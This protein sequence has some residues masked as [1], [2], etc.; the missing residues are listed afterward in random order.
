[1]KHSRQAHTP[2]VATGARSGRSS[3][4]EPLAFVLVR[5]PLL[6]VETYRALSA[7]ARNGRAWAAASGSVA[8]VP[9]SLVP[10]DPR[11][12]RALA[13]GSS[14]LLR[15]L[16]RSAPT[17]KEA[18]YT[19]GKLLR[20]LIRM[21]TRPTPY[22]L[23]AGVALGQWGSHTD[24]VL[25]DAPPRTRTRPDMAWLLSFVLAQEARPEVRAQLCFMANP[26]AYIHGDRV[27]L[28][29]RAP[30]EDGGA[31]PTVSLR[32]TGVVRRALA[33]VRTPI[34][35]H[36]LV[37]RLLTSTPGAT[38][39]QVERLIS[40]LWQHTLLLT[41]VRPPL[42]TDNPAR[43]VAQRLAA[44]PA[45]SEAAT[46]LKAILEA[47]AVW[48]T[49]PPEEGTHAYRQLVG[50]AG[51]ITGTISEPFQVDMALMLKGRQIAAT[52]GAEV[53]RAAELLLRQTPLPHGLP[54]MTAYRRAFEARYGPEREVPL[55]ELLDPDHG[56]GPPAGYGNAGVDGGSDAARSTLRQQTLRNLA[57]TAL[58]DRRL[59]VELD[60]DTLARLETWAPT[61]TT[62]PP[63][64]DLN[65][66]IA[67]PSAAA[68]DAGQF[69]IIIGPNLGAQ[70]A[71]RNLGRFADLLAPEAYFAL[72]E[73]ARAEAAR[74]PAQLR[75]ELVYLPRWF[76]SANV[77]IRPATRSHEIALA[78]SGGVDHS[79]LIPLDELLVGVRNGRF[80]IRW[81]AGN[82][83]VVVCAGH[84]LN[85]MQAPVVCQFLSDVSH[86]GQAHLS[87]FDWGM[88]AG[89][90]FLPRVQMGRS[91]LHPAQWRIDELARATELPVDPPAAFQQALRHWR[92]HWQVPQHVYL[93][94]GDNRLLLDLEDA[95]QTEELCAERR[96][97]HAG[98]H[99]VLQEALPA[100]DQI[101]LAG[102]GGHYLTELV[103]SL[104]LRPDAPQTRP[105][106]PAADAPRI[107]AATTAGSAITPVPT[108]VRLRPPGSE[109]LFA[110]LYCGRTR[111][112]ELIAGPL[113]RFAADVLARGLAEEWFFI[114][115]ADPDLHIRLR[116]RGL[117]ERLTGQLLP[118]L[119][120]W[121]TELMAAGLCL[122]LCFD[123]YDREVERY[124]GAA[125]IEVA[126]AIFAADSQAVANLLHL[127]QR[128]A[129]VIDRTTLGVLS[130]DDLLAGLGLTEA[131]RL[132][133]YREQD[134]ARQASGT[135]YRQRKAVLRTLLGDPD[136]LL[137]EPGGAQIM[138]LFSNRRAALTQPARQLRESMES[139]HLT[140]LPAELYRSYVHLHCNRLLGS[141]WST[142]QMV[143]GLLLRTREG[144]ERAPALQHVRSPGSS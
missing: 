76:R 111:E 70:A 5:A 73:V 69:Q 46:Q 41:D 37:D 102:P 85:T 118:E 72:Q 81:P 47:A 101:W 43:Y 39:V 133:W 112:E 71:G 78:V 139:G 60:D 15:A 105:A 110:K 114:R 4:Y 23:F 92:N 96:R 99:L 44:I 6:P 121:A 136:Q 55:L 29:E 104:A 143:L 51:K 45:A 27:F 113:R 116:F 128:R 40:E 67:A 74:T 122:R 80:S 3:L 141:D 20:Y 10:A 28:A 21:S 49:L 61:P 64:L 130:I 125:G 12:Q 22:G 108:T 42:T 119:C 38:L 142:E 2:T 18:P 137:A 62:A 31:A 8:F 107:P 88:A 117:P 25:A 103:V 83:D 84:M 97:L 19:R 48:D 30:T 34:R 90:P 57:L 56:L 124:G 53:A 89:F 63:S 91:V 26:A 50:E 131:E 98:G 132:Q 35:Y 129:V 16:E 138:D 93:S 68:L 13:V 1:M 32:A 33:T 65:V 87:A 7:P 126:E 75:A 135:E 66:F 109:W 144:L 94:Y 36:D 17:S 24:L 82:T 95:V 77:T 86:D 79:R 54:H 106:E 9:G 14:E 52:V 140:Q 115:Y 120:T 123:T 11:I 59:V 100:L 58:R 134:M 127:I